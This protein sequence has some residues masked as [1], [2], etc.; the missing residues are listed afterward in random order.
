MSLA[1]SP[2]M[3]LNDRQSIATALQELETYGRRE[4]ILQAVRTEQWDTAADLC[5]Q[6]MAEAAYR[7]R[8]NCA[9]IG[10]EGHKRN[11]DALK[12]LRAAIRSLR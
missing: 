2:N 7:A 9:P 11:F 8:Y 1:L 3:R 4:E 10:P 5:R 12:A 6:A